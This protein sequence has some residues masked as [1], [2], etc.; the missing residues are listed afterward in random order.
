MS[1]KFTNPCLNATINPV[2]ITEIASIKI[3]TSGTTTF[4]E[5]TVIVT[6]TGVAS[7]PLLCGSRTY[8]VVDT[9]NN[10]VDWVSITKA[11]ETYTVTAT[12]FTANDDLVKTHNVRLKVVLDTYTSIATSTNHFTITVDYA[13]CS[14]AKIVWQAG[15]EATQTLLVGAASA[16]IVLA[17][18]V[19]TASSDGANSTDPG[20]RSCYRLNTTNYQ[21][22]TDNTVSFTALTES[23]GKDITWITF[24]AGV[25]GKTITYE[26]PT[27]S[28]IGVYHLRL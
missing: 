24:N 21:C 10:A 14:C 27:A 4:T 16:N 8:S 12:P 2:D 3:G 17:Q 26:T 20:V 19:V 9:N 13:T 11:G 7:V 6:A 1:I 18:S 5:A 15:T 28:K 22:S 25:N 23:T